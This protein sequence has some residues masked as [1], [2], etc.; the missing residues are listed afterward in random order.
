MRF[1]S[2]RRNLHACPCHT[3]VSKAGNA[4][5]AGN[6]HV[7]LQF[8]P[9]SRKHFRVHISEQTPRAAT[10]RVASQTL[11]ASSHRH[12]LH[13]V[14]R[15]HPEVIVAF[16]AATVALNRPWHP[17]WRAT[18]RRNDAAEHAPL[19][20]LQPVVSRCHRVEVCC[21]G[22]QDAFTKPGVRLPRLQCYPCSA[23]IT[24]IGSRLVSAHHVWFTT[25]RRP[26]VQLT[27]P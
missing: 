27:S 25:E 9:S 22:T 14:L 6:T 26:S 24:A 13:A 5:N 8:Q 12:N 20:R 23:G 1:I 7:Y 2:A 18:T 11:G 10:K 4:G 15:S 3:Q 21:Y 19:P 16:F 17:R